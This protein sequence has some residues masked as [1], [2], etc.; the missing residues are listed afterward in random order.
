MDQGDILDSVMKTIRIPTIPLLEATSRQFGVM[1]GSKMEI[2]L[3]KAI[4]MDFDKSRVSFR[5]A[6]SLLV[7]ADSAI[8]SLIQY[9]YGCIEQTISSTLPNAIALKFQS[10]IGTTIDAKQATNNLNA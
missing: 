9:P 10:L 2:S 8:R 7:N 6:S 1:T 4:G 3:P 5:V